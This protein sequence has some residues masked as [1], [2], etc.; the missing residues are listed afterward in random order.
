MEINPIGKSCYV[1]SKGIESLFFDYL[2]THNVDIRIREY[3]ILMVR[4]AE[5]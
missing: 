3:L 2:R 1:E 4:Y 5:R